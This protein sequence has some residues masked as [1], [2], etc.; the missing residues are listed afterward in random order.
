MKK[1][2][3]IPNRDF[4]T[5]SGDRILGLWAEAYREIGT[6]SGKNII[7][8][9]PTG[10]GK[11]TS[12]GL[13]TGNRL[14]MMFSVSTGET[15]FLITPE[16]QRS[17]RRK[18]GELI[19]KVFVYQDAGGQ[20]RPVIGDTRVSQT[21][22]AQ[23]FPF[24]T[25][26]SLIDTGGTWDNRGLEQNII[27]AF[28]TYA[29]AMKSEAVSFVLMYNFSKLEG[30]AA[31]FLQTLKFVKEFI[32]FDQYPK[33]VS[34]IITNVTRKEF[35]D[36]GIERKVPGDITDVVAELKTLVSALREKGV[37]DNLDLID[38]F[39]QK[40]GRAIQVINLPIQEAVLQG[41]RG[42]MVSQEMIDV[43]RNNLVRVPMSAD[44]RA[45]VIEAI[46]QSI[47]PSSKCLQDYNAQTEQLKILN[48]ELNR[49][50]SEILSLN[51][52][53]TQINSLLSEQAKRALSQDSGASL[54][55]IKRS[56]VL[57]QE[58]L[59][60]EKQA[61]H[62]QSEAL[63]TQIA[64]LERENHRLESSKGIVLADTLPVTLEGVEPVSGEA[65]QALLGEGGSV[66]AKV[67]GQFLDSATKITGSMLEE[68]HIVNHSA[69]AGIALGGQ[70]VSA[71]LQTIADTKVSKPEKAERKQ[72]FHAKAPGGAMIREAITGDGEWSGRTEIRQE[73]VPTFS[74]VLTNRNKTPLNSTIKV[75]VYESEALETRQKIVQ[76]EGEIVRIQGQ[77]YAKSNESSGREHSLKLADWLTG[78]IERGELDQKKLAIKVEELNAQKSALT[79][80]RDALQGAME[81]NRQFIINTILPQYG[82]LKDLT[83]SVR[84]G[85]E[86]QPL[87]Q[88]YYKL[89]STFK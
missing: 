65:K 81:Q 51:D 46:Y 42:L 3:A 54:E 23:S 4:S 32:P 61:I 8:L 36:E 22:Y 53:I 35:D 89:C 15:R 28:S 16:E 55:E 74:A 87:I 13:L 30:K 72:T 14:K 9:G 19:E 58:L 70:A 10:A 41:V 37:V 27:N 33:S 24:A 38:F 40:E 68:G 85:L 66:A 43:R 25:G 67:G 69:A 63:K 20:V 12:I 39:L 83:N 60:S 29:V 77:L 82:H 71:I 48:K 21:L 17:Y 1:Y 62:G 84:M 75:Y 73:G 59:G 47:V 80:Q 5:L 79:Q 34:L 26:S 64:Q 88:A 44:A 52:Q 45:E 56:L 31:E 78:E 86:D 6:I 2:L 7:L 76:N 18:P 57:K 49:Q 50:A 11:S